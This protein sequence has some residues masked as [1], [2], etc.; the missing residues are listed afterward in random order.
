M[1]LRL[2]NSRF[3]RTLR[4]AVDLPLTVERLHLRGVCDGTT[5]QPNAVGETLACWVEGLPENADL[6]NVR[7]WIGDRKLRILWMADHDA[8]GIR[9]IN[10]AVPPAAAP[11]DF[12]M[13]CG[14]VRSESVQVL[15][16]Q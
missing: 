5:W 14:G 10:A 11:G 2:T 9:Q 7:L 3:G 16:L 4:I 8:S 12:H 1:R 15:K 6:A 13:E